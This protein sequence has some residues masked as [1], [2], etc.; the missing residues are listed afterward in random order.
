MLNYV[1]FFGTVLM[2][3]YVR[4]RRK[5]SFYNVKLSHKIF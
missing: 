2:N 1:W 3:Q 5:V 4:Q